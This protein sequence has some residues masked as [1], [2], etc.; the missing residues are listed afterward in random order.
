MGRSGPGTGART[1]HLEGNNRFF[2]HRFSD[3]P[4]KVIS[5]FDPFQIG[6]ND[7]GV[8]I[9]FQIIDI[10]MKVDADSISH[11]Y[12]FAETHPSHFGVMGKGV[13]DIPA[14]GEH[15][16]GALAYARNS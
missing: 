4:D 11:A 2:L 9:I 5:I 7:L 12:Y 10:L 16:D 13:D 1:S 15:R 3:D 8:W 14:L 6:H